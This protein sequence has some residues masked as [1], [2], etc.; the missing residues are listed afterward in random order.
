M[1]WYQMVVFWKNPISNIPKR[2]LGGFRLLNNPPKSTSNDLYIA[3]WT[4][5]T[6]GAINARTDERMYP[7]KIGESLG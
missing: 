2:S 1:A 4:P 5:A 3:L 6:T 7:Q